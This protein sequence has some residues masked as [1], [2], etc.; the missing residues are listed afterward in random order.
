MD[1]LT[2]KDVDGVVYVPIDT[3]SILNEECVWL[4]ITKLAEYEDLEEQ[5]LLI[6]LPCKIG[7]TVYE[8][9]PDRGF[10]SE[11]II[12]SAEIYNYGIFFHWELKKGI[13]SNLRGFQYD[14][15]GETVFLTCK[16]AEQKLKEK[17]E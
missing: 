2:R 15:I 10:I 4:P 16:E 7:D 5:G 14:R 12:T 13:Y 17:E 8:P 6:R 3:D 9:R 11:Y 1:R